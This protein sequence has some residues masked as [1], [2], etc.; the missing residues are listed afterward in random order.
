MLFCIKHSSWVSVYIELPLD[1]DP[2]DIN[3]DSIMMNGIISAQARPFEIGDYDGDGIE[4]L[5][6]KFKREEVA[7][8]LAV[9][10]QADIIVT[11]DV[12]GIPFEGV[13]S[14][15]VTGKAGGKAKGFSADNGEA[16]RGQTLQST[17]LRFKCYYYHNDHLGTPQI[18]TD[19]K[20]T[21]VWKAVYEELKG[22]ALEN[23]N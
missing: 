23:R 12:S 4:D 2:A 16:D 10:E 22:S 17:V 3:I 5:M 13:D 11:G 14:I 21:V 19:Y 6:V 20:G 15:R 8:I 1:Y 18:M 7:N 9:T